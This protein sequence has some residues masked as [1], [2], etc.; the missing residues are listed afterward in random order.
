MNNPIS[1]CYLCGEPLTDE[2]S[3]D[4]VPPKQLYAKQIL[5]HRHNLNLLTIPVHQFCN[6]S[7]QHDEDYFVCSLM[8]FARGSYS[9][10]ALRK[11]IIDDSKRRLLLQKVLHEFERRPSGL[12]LPPGIVA[13][14]FEGDRILR[15]AWKIVR[16]LYF[17]HFGVFIPENAPRACKVVPPGEPPPL[18]FFFLPDEP[19]HGQHAGVFDYKFASY[20]EI[21]NLNYW[22]ILLWDELILIVTFQHPV[23]NC[24]ECKQRFAS[25]EH[26]LCDAA[27]ERSP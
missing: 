5:Q 8:P 19:I 11:K 17:S 6:R 12:I 16:G 14:K 18:P 7:Y 15:V 10:D 9:G 1:I 21:H 23:C 22:A 24:E 20:P 2:I 25:H 3:A 4:H 13:K 27:M 26:D